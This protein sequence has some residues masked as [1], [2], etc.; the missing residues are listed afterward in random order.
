M[1]MS[2]QL[3]NT[4]KR[5][6]VSSVYNHNFLVLDGQPPGPDFVIIPARDRCSKLARY[7]QSV[8]SIRI[9][10]PWVLI[11]VD[12]GFPDAAGS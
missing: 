6:I 11:I 10:W 7:L 8:Q 1:V 4:G 2:H 5:S 12:N 3:R 9:E